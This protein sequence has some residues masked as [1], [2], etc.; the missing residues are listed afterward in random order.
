MPVNCIHTRRW[1]TFPVRFDMKK[2]FA[3]ALTLALL[4]AGLPPLRAQTEQHAEL[5]ANVKPVENQDGNVVLE[6]DVTVKN[7]APEQAISLVEFRY[8][9]ELIASV[10]SISARSSAFVRSVP[11]HMSLTAMTSDVEVEVS[12][13]DFNGEAIS[14]W[15]VVQGEQAEPKLSFKRVASATAVSAGESV[16]LTY[17]VKN[18]GSVLLSDLQITDDLPGVGEVGK[19]D[20]LYPGDMREF[21]VEVKLDQ[22]V[23]S[24]PQVRYHASGSAQSAVLVLDALS[25]VIYNPKLTVTLKSDVTAVEAGESVTLVCSVVNEGNVAFQNVAISDA[26]LGTIIDSAQI[27]VGKAYSWN[28]LIKPV[29]SQ[30]YMF[31]VRAVDQSGKSYT[32]TSNI[33]SVEVEQPANPEDADTLEVSVTANTRELEQPGEITFNL[34]LRN[35]GTQDITGIAVSDQNGAVLERINSLPPGDKILPIAVN[36]TETCDTYFVVDATMASGTKVQRVTVPMTITVGVVQKG[37]A[38]PSPAV[39]PEPTPLVTVNN[40]AQRGIAPWIIALLIVVAL[41]IVAC[42]VVLVLLQARAR[43]RRYEEEDDY[44]PPP[45]Y[46]RPREDDAPPAD[47]YDYRDEISR[48]ATE[49]SRP[50]PSEEPPPRRRPQPAPDEEEDVRTV[51]KAPRPHAEPHTRRND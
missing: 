45:S 42:V 48:V 40:G 19:I 3:L 20:L 9:N 50:V 8:E 41:L 10:D 5:T 1:R 29:N 34:L 46:G 4:L 14:R 17:M 13:I 43:G 11:L 49:Y 44:L 7:G 25:L 51:Y 28:K 26:T 31:T 47:P 33:V 32:A 21:N 6:I 16:K 30:N 23:K 37:E 35:T 36:V 12:Y 27:E 15:M 39:S 24:Q 18:E 38:T 2:V 22:D